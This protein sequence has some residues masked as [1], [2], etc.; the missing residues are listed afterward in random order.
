ML[1]NCLI[2]TAVFMPQLAVESVARAGHNSL[3]LVRLFFFFFPD[4][5][6]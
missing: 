6:D 5:G 2:Q 4:I 1:F 3:A